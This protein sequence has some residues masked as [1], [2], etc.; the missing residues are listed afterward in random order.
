MTQPSGEH[1]LNVVVAQI[2]FI[3]F[4]KICDINQ[5]HL[6]YTLVRSKT[7]EQFEASKGCGVVLL[8]YK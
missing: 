4:R 5:I 1:V 2:G 8:G 7:L 3:H 6:S